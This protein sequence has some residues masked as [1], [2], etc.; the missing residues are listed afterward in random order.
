M[1]NNVVVYN[2][3][4]RELTLALRHTIKN[5]FESAGKQQFADRAMHFKIFFGLGSWLVSYLLIIS[6]WFTGPLLF[7]VALLHG[8]T[9]L[10][11]AFNISHDANH[12]ALSPKKSV[13]RLLSYSLDLIGVSSYLWRVAHNQEH[14]SFVNIAHVDPSIRGYGVLRFTPFER[15]KKSFKYQHIYGL[16]LYGLSTFNYVTF[17]DF[18]ILYRTLRSG[19]KIPF[20]TIFL[21]LFF[22]LFYYTYTFVLPMTL[23]GLSFGEVFLAFFVIHFVI[24]QILTFVFQ[25]GHLTEEAHYPE[26]EDGKVSD[27]WTVH[28][29]K[30][31][32]DFAPKSHLLPWLV[33]GINLHVIHHLYPNICH[34][35][36]KALSPL[37]KQTVEAHGLSYREIPTFGKAITSH[38]SLLKE[39]G[40]T[41]H[42]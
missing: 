13:N 30:T 24:G 34:I 22:K 19:V 12:D 32:G 31:T 15:L 41:E 39:L 36:Y 7:L 11:I 25:C 8:L 4:D 29:I 18:R 21:T 37:L 23:L 10:F 16:F 40:A 26:V 2:R 28:I 17:K 5:Y 35:H 14:H 27:S 33:G 3:A 1:D 42:R 6:G 20:T 38:I 9:H